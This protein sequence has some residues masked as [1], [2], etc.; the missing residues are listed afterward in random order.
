MKNSDT[1]DL[2]DL[3]GSFDETMPTPAASIKLASVDGE[4]VAGIV[5]ADIREAEE[6]RNPREFHGIELPALMCSTGRGTSPPKLLSNLFNVKTILSAHKEVVVLFAFD[7]LLGKIVRRH[8]VPSPKERGV[9]Q[10]YPNPERI[11]DVDSQKL[12]C[13][14]QTGGMLGV[15]LEMV[16]GAIEIAA[17]ENSFHPI[18]DY[19][20]RLKWDGTPRIATFGHE[21]LGTLATEYEAEIFKIFFVGAVARIMKRGC[22]MD[23][24]VT[25]EGD[26]GLRKSMSWSILGG[27]WFSDTLPADVSTKDAAD[28]VSGKWM[29]EIAEM[30]CMQK[31]SAPVLKQF[32]T[33]QV[34]EYRPSYGRHEVHRPR[35]CIFVGTTNEREYLTD[36]TGNRRF[37][38]VAVKKVEADKL[39]ADRDQLWAEAVHLYKAGTNWWPE[40]EFEE[41]FIK[42]QQEERMITDP[43]QELI[44]LKLWKGA[45]LRDGVKMTDRIC[46]ADLGL[47]VGKDSDKLTP[48]NQQRLRKIMV[49]LGWEADKVGGK[50]W[51]YRPGT[52]PEG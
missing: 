37:L 22:K 44:E 2:N 43:W 23:Y 11:E 1:I 27:A 40:E 19:F 30:H 48:D 35:Q 15:K 47:L 4:L 42:P 9:P 38:P 18:K 13:W 7:E 52:K 6:E 34:E 20:K 16:N 28:Y 12:L 24:V 8:P 14:F 36:S 21:Y 51:W 46:Y 29:I 32:I 41:K 26:Q 3:I 5:E 45:I 39:T 31:A 33:R 50:I 17:R 49:G 10:K 25:L